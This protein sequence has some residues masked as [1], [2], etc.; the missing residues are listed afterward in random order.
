MES[1]SSVMKFGRLSSG[2]GRGGTSPRG[3]SATNIQ[4]KRNRKPIDAENDNSL[5]IVRAVIAFWI[6]WKRAMLML[7][8]WMMWL[9][10]NID[11]RNAVNTDR[12][13][14]TVNLEYFNK[15]VDQV[16]DNREPS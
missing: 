1:E 16:R 5:R 6:P 2:M 10:S 9:K 8:C 13:A 15:L 14:I 12:C 11:P 3:G 7:P 4:K